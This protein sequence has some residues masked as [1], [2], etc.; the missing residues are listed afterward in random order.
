VAA[1]ASNEDFVSTPP[2]EGLGIEFRLLKNLCRDDVEALDLLDQV[3]Q[4]QSGN[5]TGNNQHGIVN[6]INNSSKRDSPVGTSEAA[7][8]RRL[9]KSA[10]GFHG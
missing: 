8:L 2:L 5:P 4:S 1:N 10:P 9:R 3:T 6:N 7:A